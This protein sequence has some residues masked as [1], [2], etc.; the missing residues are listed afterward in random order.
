[1]P[2]GFHSLN[3]G[4]FAFGFFNIDT[5]L[6]LL[7]HYFLFA[8]AFCAYTIQLTQQTGHGSCESLWDVYDIP[9]RVQ[10]GD[11]MG[12]IHGVRHT[13]FIGDVY[14]LFPFPQR[15]ADFRQK[16]EGFLNQ[17]AIRPILEKYAGHA[18]IPFRADIE[19]ETVAIGEYLFTKEVF[20]QLIEYVWLGGYPRW[21]DDIRPDYVMGM[22]RSSEETSSWLFSGL[23][24][25]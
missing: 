19:H 22:R 25:S 17:P 9:T 13:G 6:L 23:V 10:I 14:R 11:L 4:D 21:R 3:R 2:L 7:D 16:P 5:D 8:D 1:L 18:K 24:F 12:A 15:Q 20:Q